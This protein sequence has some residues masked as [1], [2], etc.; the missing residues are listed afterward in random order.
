MVDGESQIKSLK[1]QRSR[2]F[3]LAQTVDG[4]IIQ[5]GDSTRAPKSLAE[6]QQSGQETFNEKPRLG[7]IYAK[8]VT[9]DGSHV[10]EF[11]P[12]KD[13]PG[14]GHSEEVEMPV[15]LT[16]D[17]NFREIIIRRGPGEHGIYEVQNFGDTRAGKAYTLIY[18]GPAIGKSPTE[19]PN[20][21]DSIRAAIPRTAIQPL[22]K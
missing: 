16:S 12:D 13:N 11:V 18:R 4:N 20:H 8:A 2:M 9:P 15:G 10:M 6:S 7:R 21:L 14:Q 22:R 19:K 5:V 3:N 17:S 1:D